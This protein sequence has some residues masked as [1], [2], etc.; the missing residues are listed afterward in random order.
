MVL[1][2]A[3]GQWSWFWWVLVSH[4]FGFGWVLV[5]SGRGFW[6]VLASTGDGFDG[7]LFPL[8]LVLVG[9]CVQR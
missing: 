8:F 9:A 2:G 6:S 4:G 5:S 7:C 1:V 3:R